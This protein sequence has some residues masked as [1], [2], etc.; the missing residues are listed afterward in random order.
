VRLKASTSLVTIQTIENWKLRLFDVKQYVDS[1]VF[2][3]RNRRS[4]L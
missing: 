2:R 3:L 1:F 4:P